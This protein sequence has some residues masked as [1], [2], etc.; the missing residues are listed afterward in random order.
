MKAFITGGT[1]FVGS[2]LVDF[3]MLGGAEVRCLV[4]DQEKW[5]EGKSYTKIRGDMH[6]LP[7]LK[8]GMKGADIVF[9]VAALVK[10]PD[11]P[12][13]YRNNVDAT[14]NVVRMAQKEG[15]KKIIV[16]SSLAA[17]GPS[18]GSP[19][20]EDILHDPV[21]MYGK[22][23]KKMEEMIHSITDGSSSI[24]IIRPPVVYGPR[25]DQIYTVF[26]MATRGFFP[27]V[28]K[29]GATNRISLVYISDLVEGIMLA[30]NHQNKD[31]ETYY[32]SSEKVYTWDEIKAVT[33]DVLGKKLRPLYISPAL[34]KKLAG[35]VEYV[36]SFFGHYPVMN[37]DKANEMILEWTCSVDKAKKDLD[38]RQRVSLNAGITKT[39]KWYKKHNWL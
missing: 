7:A 24:T 15:I 19:L 8:E 10:A 31:P 11:Y 20:S 23:K 1:G 26:K 3:L 16:L 35:T 6:D 27:I 14:E 38:Y 12:T 32:I 30:A 33:A 29:K 17:A 4:R 22:S 13:F 39:I 18:N 37:R 25:E 36:S 2:H 5:L 34:T 21:S 9:H 28:G